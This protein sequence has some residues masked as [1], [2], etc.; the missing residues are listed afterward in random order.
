MSTAKKS[1]TVQNNSKLPTGYKKTLED[2]S[3]FAS[4]AFSILSLAFF[5][6]NILGLFLSFLG[7]GFG[8]KG[9]SSIYYKNLAKV[10]L[11]ISILST[12]IILLW[13]VLSLALESLPLVG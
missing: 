5:F 13:S 4:I 1:P 11:I 9:L 12:I 2:N 3:A 7:I 8:L 6:I 10:G